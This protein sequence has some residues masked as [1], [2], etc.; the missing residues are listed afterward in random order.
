M[1]KLKL[2][3]YFSGIYEDEEYPRFKVL[4]DGK[5]IKTK[6]KFD[7]ITS[8]DETKIAEVGLV[9]KEDLELALKSA[10]KNKHKIR[11]LAY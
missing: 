9:S 5:W 6:D 3:E 11:D 4:I 10:D 7:L 1:E 2:S 8:V